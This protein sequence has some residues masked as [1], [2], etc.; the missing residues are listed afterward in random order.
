MLNTYSWAGKSPVNEHRSS[1][2]LFA[3]KLFFVVL[4]IYCTKGLKRKRCPPS[5]SV[6]YTPRLVCIYRVFV[7]RTVMGA[8]TWEP[9]R[10]ILGW[11]ISK[12]LEGRT[13]APA[14]FYWGDSWRRTKSFLSLILA[15]NM[16]N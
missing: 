9:R 4:W 1:K 8:D 14:R 10:R 3:F 7:C 15:R 2:L 5:G 16:R 6:G 11:N 13:R 12:G